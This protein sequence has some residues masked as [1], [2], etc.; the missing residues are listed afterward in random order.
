MS[1]TWKLL[2]VELLEPHLGPT[3]LNMSIKDTN[4][5]VF[6]AVRTGEFNSM[7]NDLFIYLL[8]TFLARS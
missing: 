7:N 6:I 5:K 3:N 4:L 8:L 2:E 1:I